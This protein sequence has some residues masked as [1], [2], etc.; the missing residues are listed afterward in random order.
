[1]STR[2]TN[3]ELEALV[4][5]LNVATKSPLTYYVGATRQTSIGHYFIESSCGRV[6]VSRIANSTGASS[7]ALGMVGHGS[8]AEC[9]AALRG[10][11]AMAEDSSYVDHKAR[12]TIERIQIARYAADILLSHN[13]HCELALKGFQE[14][15]YAILDESS[16]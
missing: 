9:A 12:K 13:P 16:K 6:N 8:K 1:M 4:H 10:A 15:A 7:D 3:A 11:V 14:D 2:T 5:R